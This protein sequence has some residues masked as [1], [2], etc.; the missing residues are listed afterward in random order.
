MKNEKPKID[1][2]KTDTIEKM[3]VHP[4]YLWKTKGVKCEMEKSKILYDMLTISWIIKDVND[5]LK[6]LSC[7]I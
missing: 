3:L 1:Y 6:K 7:S 2:C 5:R 4:C